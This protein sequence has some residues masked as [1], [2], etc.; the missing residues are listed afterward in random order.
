M[1][2]DNN[3]CQG[4]RVGQVRNT[5]ACTG[6]TVT[7]L[8]RITVNPEYPRVHGDNLKTGAHTLRHSGIPP[9]ARGQRLSAIRPK[10]LLEYPRL[11]GDNHRLVQE[12]C[13]EPGIPPLARGQ[14]PPDAPQL[15][16]QRNTPACTGTTCRRGRQSSASREYPRLH[17]DN[18]SA[19]GRYMVHYGIPPRARGQ[20]RERASR[21]D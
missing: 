17:G 6:T 11:H 12:V 2:G 18:Q 15:R 21:W 10:V 9:R 14:R 3:D 13:R 16:H 20:R 7:F 4:R 1:H 8:P 5:P 19:D